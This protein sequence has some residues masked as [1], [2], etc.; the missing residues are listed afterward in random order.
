[1]TTVDEMQQAEEKELQN[2]QSTI[3][4]TSNDQLVNRLITL[5]LF[6]TN[7]DPKNSFFLGHYIYLQ[8]AI[9]AEIL[10]RMEGGADDGDN[11]QTTE[12]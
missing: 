10:R 2:I 7:V 1:M 11:S 8:R 4:G 3:R 5:N 12:D 9:R 6:L